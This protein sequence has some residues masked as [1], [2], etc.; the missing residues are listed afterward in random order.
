M[1]SGLFALLDDIAA[2]AKG[3]VASLDD[4]AVQAVKASKNAA[5]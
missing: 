2:I 4:V 1:I 5:G 3:A